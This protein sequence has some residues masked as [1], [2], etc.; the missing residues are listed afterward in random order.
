MSK[1]NPRPPYYAGNEFAD[2]MKH[3]GGLLH[4]VGASNY[5]VMR[6]NRSHPEFADGFGNTY[7]H[8][9][10]LTFWRGKFYL[11]YL[12]N[13]V[14]E[15]TGGGQSFIVQSEDGINWGKPQTSFP[16][17]R[18]PAGQYNCAD[19]SVIDVAEGTFGIMHQRMGFYHSKDDRLLV[20]GFYGHTPHHD[21]CPW[22]N[23]GIGR[24]VREVFEDGTMGPIYFIRYLNYAGWTEETLP[25][26]VY[27]HAADKSFVTT[28]EE[29][30][31]DKL[32]TEQWTEE[33]GPADTT[34]GLKIEKDDT[35]DGMSANT[36][37]ESASSFCCYHIDDNT[38]VALWKQGKVGISA[39]GGLNW[40]I[41][42]EPSFVTSGAKSWGQKT[43]DGK[44]AIC[45]DNSL[46]SE[47]R[48]PLVVVTSDDGIQFDNMACVF[49]ELPPRRYDGT[50][51]DFGPQYIRGIWENHK[52]Y[53]AGALWICH[54]IN[55]EDISVSRIPLPVR[56]SVDEQ[57][58]DNF[59]DCSDGY[60]KDWNIYS[61]KWSPVTLDNVQGKACIKMADKDPCDYAR[62]MRI[63]PKSEKVS[64]SLD[65]MA[66]GSYE[67]DLEIE[68]ANSRDIPACRILLGG[69]WLKVRY[70]SNVENAFEVTADA[71]WHKLEIVLDCPNNEYYVLWDGNEFR[72]GP[73][74][75]VNK[76]NDVERLI[77]RTKPRRYL[78][79][80]EIYP[81]TP[82]LPGVDEPET[83]RVYFIRNVRTQA[84]SD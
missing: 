69:G 5:Q 47:H 57:I 28:C 67:K 55:K 3:D 22:R 11:E 59:E 24:V 76:T 40:Q 37:F 74:R 73:C 35:D 44:F 65:V 33:H 72:D 58:N 25:F 52:E 16:V 46:S 63:F 10:M 19:G 39:D 41:K 79:N 49:G 45:Y 48:Y 42:Y 36:P 60:I 68:L 4:A 61:T 8:A 66:G 1:I 26:P 6:A 53:P 78:P 21:T 2:M 17:I 34:I 38:V 32:V 51:K 64:V 82:D 31:A 75:P 62:A 12:S 9:P 18:V 70:G 77:L 80:N 7:N 23:Y 54:S 56:R 43:E 71:I 50:Y 13:P 84:F 15:H 30:L 83:Q 81:R 14:H 27:T 29:L 20:S